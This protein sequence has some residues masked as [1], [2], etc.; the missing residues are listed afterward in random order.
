MYPNLCPSFRILYGRAFFFFFFSANGWNENFEKCAIQQN[1]GMVRLWKLWKQPCVT[2]ACRGKGPGCAHKLRL[3]RGPRSRCGP[4]PTVPRSSSQGPTSLREVFSKSYFFCH[5]LLVFSPRV[6]KLSLPSLH[7]FWIEVILSP[8]STPLERTSSLYSR[9]E[10]SSV[11]KGEVR[12]K[13]NFIQVFGFVVLRDVVKVFPV[14]SSTC[15]RKTTGRNRARSHS[16]A[17][18]GLKTKSD[19]KLSLPSPTYLIRYLF[20][21]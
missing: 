1:H 20:V 7:H 13:M 5:Y 9:R 17:W 2:W 8:R 15:A 12:R 3:G 21:Y 4:L 11:S 10:A 6:V 16:G 14:S 19:L 18:R